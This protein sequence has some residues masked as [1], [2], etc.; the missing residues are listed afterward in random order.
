MEVI[1][2][3]YT[4]ALRDFPEELPEKRRIDA[5]SRYARELERVFGTPE[6]VAAALQ[7]MTSLEES[8]PETVSDGEL[9]LLKQ[10]GKASNAARQAGFRDLGEAEGAYFDVRLS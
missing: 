6:Q 2:V 9:A 3:I 4:V 8:P 10:W 7:T 1:D 5:E